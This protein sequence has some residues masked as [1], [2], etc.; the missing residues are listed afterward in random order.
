MTITRRELLEGFGLAS[1]YVFAFGCAG[2]GRSIRRSNEDLSGEVRTWLRD[3]VAVIHG[4]GLAGH[5]LAVS[6][7]HTVAAQDV[8]GANVNHAR[9]DGVVLTARDAHGRREHV[10][11]ELT[12]DGV[13]AAARVLAGKARPAR[14]EFGPPPAPAPVPRPDPA[15]LSD[16]ALIDSV[17]AVARRDQGLSSRIVYASGL[18]EVDDAMVWSVAAHRDL[19]QRLYRV[20]RALTRVAWNGTRPI[21]SEVSRAWAGGIQDQTF[22]DEELAHAREVALALMTPGAFADGEHALVLAPDVVAGIVDA[23]ARTLYTT[24]AAHRPEVAARLQPGKPIAAQGFTLVD[25]PTVAGA[26]GGFRFDDDGELAA[27]VT[28]IDRGQ[29]AGRITRHGR[30][31]HTGPLELM[32][33]H[34]RVAA[35]T[36]TELAL[37]EGFL[38]E[39]NRGVSIDPASDRIVIEVQRALEIRHGQRTGRIYAEIELVGELATLLASIGDATKVTTT[40]GIRDDRDGQP[41]WRSVEAPWL[42]AKGLVRARRRQA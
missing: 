4:A 17:N 31:G 14:I 42:R 22:S 30:P 38:L 5:A 11:T 40:L 20:R 29:L 3:A 32:P 8:L 23:A 27:P 2:P 33:S 34:L 35:G 39:G 19:E 26:Y 13:M 12:R 16:S 36:A 24:R 37:D 41:R 15:Q 9:C 18:L 10:T 6:R 21:I 1:A 25:D 28:L 7:T